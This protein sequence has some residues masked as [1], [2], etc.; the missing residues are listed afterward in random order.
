MKC[1]FF[2]KLALP[3]TQIPLLFGIQQSAM[4]YQATIVSKAM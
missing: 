2:S 3:V 4:A 1:Q